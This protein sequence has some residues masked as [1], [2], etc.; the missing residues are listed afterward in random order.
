[1][2]EGYMIQLKPLSPS[3]WPKQEEFNG[4]KVILDILYFGIR[5]NLSPFCDT[6]K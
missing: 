3:Q 5:Y 6:S 2:L 1:M 4:K